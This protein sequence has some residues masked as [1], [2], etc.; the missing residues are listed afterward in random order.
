MN[1]P[2]QIY[3]FRADWKLSHTF[4][5][6]Q[7]PDWLSLEVNWQGYKISTIPWIAEVAQLLGILTLQEDTP[8]SWIAYLE[9]L[10]LRGIT[11]VS[12][13]DFFESRFYY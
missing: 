10:G 2:K 11:Q 1:Q 7:V 13:K 4:N 6:H 5:K 12:Y 9:S 8:E 3:Y